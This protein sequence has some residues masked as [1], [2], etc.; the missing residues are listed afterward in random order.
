MLAPLRDVT[1]W[2]SASTSEG[3]RRNPLTCG[4]ADF[5][6]A[7]SAASPQETGADRPMGLGRAARRAVRGPVV[8]E[9]FGP[10]GLLL[11]WTF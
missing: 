11:F 6:I 9:S 8:Q 7:K 1:W 5:K 2:S 4:Y 3:L 10:D